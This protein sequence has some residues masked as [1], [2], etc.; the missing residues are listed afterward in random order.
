MYCAQNNKIYCSDCNKSYIT[1]KYSNHSKTK[2]HNINVMKKR[3][4][5]CNNAMTHSNNHDLTCSMNK[6]SPE[7]NENLKTDFSNGKKIVKSEQTK[8][9]DIDSDI[10]LLYF[11]NYRVGASITEAK[12][13]LQKL[14]RDMGITWGEYVFYLNGYACI[15]IKM[16]T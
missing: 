13:V 1:T 12:A 5:S 3:C 6:I 14:Y 7:S 9:K 15:R 11:H 16:G 10:L 8:E 4:C 2:G